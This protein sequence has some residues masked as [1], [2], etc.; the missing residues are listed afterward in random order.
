MVTTFLHYL[1]VTQEDKIWL[2]KL[3]QAEMYVVSNVY[4]NYHE[5]F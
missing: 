1:Q 2:V 3:V 5:A 4:N